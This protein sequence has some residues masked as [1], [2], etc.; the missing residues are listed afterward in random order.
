MLPASVAC[1]GQ[2]RCWKMR[3]LHGQRD[4]RRIPASWYSRTDHGN[5]K[6]FKCQFDI[7]RK[8]RIYER[9]VRMRAKSTSSLHLQCP[10][11]L[12]Q[13]EASCI[14]DVVQAS[15]LEIS[16]KLP[17]HWDSKWSHEPGASKHIALSAV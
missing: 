15:D 7:P 13:S 11:R 5:H 6:H 4:E 1:A 12:F 14:G 16:S 9:Q 17:S 2:V 10:M 8:L 3:G